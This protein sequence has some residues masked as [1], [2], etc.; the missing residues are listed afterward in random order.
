MA[1]TCM[2]QVKISYLAL[3]LMPLHPRHPSRRLISGLE[4]L[5]QHNLSCKR[6]YV[7]YEVIFSPLMSGD[8][9]QRK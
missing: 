5:S 2:G 9:K 1:D 7:S 4:S 8:F 6:K 3:H